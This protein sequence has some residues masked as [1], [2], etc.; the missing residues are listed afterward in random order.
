MKEIG[1][2]LYFWEREGFWGST[3]IPR[4]SY[5][6]EAYDVCFKREE[7]SFWFEHRNN[8]IVEIVKKYPPDG[9]FYD[10]GGGNGYVTRRLL[11]EGFDAVLIEPGIGGCRNARARGIKK[12][13]CST[14][15]DAKFKEKI[16]PAVGIFDVLEHIKDDL[17]F[18][19]KIWSHLV[20]GGKL[21]LTVPA[22][23]LLWSNKD[24][25]HYRRYTLK[26]LVT[27]LKET[28]YKIRYTTYFFSFLPLPIFFLRTLPSKLGLVQNHHLEEEHQV[29]GIKKKV[30]A[31]CLKK[32]LSKLKRG[33]ISFGAS[34]LV[35]AEK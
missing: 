5:S 29:R 35:V 19:K 25:F 31:W 27:K 20:E 8:V 1:E 11:N 7:I 6:E 21:Y 9:T 18:L 10:V 24:R 32:E 13:I 14:L 15:E 22:Y 26:E 12:V 17:V 4:V 34:C 16:F 28:N 2:R 3:I 23:N 30:I 33:R